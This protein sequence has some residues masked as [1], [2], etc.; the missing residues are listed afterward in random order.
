MKRRR[1]ALREE[2]TTITTIRTEDSRMMAVTITNNTTMEVSVTF[3]DPPINI[4][5]VKIE[6]SMMDPHPKEWIDH[7]TMIEV[8][9]E[10]MEV[11][12]ITNITLMAIMTINKITIK[13]D[14]NSEIAATKNHPNSNREMATLITDSEMIIQEVLVATTTTTKTTLE[15]SLAAAI[16]VAI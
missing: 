1:R 2:T 12:T 15:M 13:K 14:P 8:A 6:N 5:E 10:T 16:E 7:P 9:T 3:R 11:I 4:E